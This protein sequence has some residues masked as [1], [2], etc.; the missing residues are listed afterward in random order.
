MEGN[1]RRVVPRQ[2]TYRC[3]LIS[4]SAGR[5]L[6]FLNLTCLR[7]H[8]SPVL[9]P[10]TITKTLMT[11]HQLTPAAWIPPMIL[12]SCPSLFIH[13][14]TSPP[15]SSEFYPLPLVSSPSSPPSFP[16]FLLFFDVSLLPRCQAPPPRHLF[17]LLSEGLKTFL[18]HC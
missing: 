2:Q 5:Q 11:H 3:I 8:Y 9:L 12:L 14:S 15:S 7:Y 4:H 6:I 13:P 10:L 1:R 16:S 17:L 18:L